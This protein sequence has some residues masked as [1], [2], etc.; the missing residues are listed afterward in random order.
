MSKWK[1][2]IRNKI[3]DSKVEE[4]V[5]A[6]ADGEDETISQV[7]KQLLE[8][9]STLE[10]SY[11]IP[12][13]SRIESVSTLVFI[14]ADIQ[15]D[16]EDEA[17]TTT[18]AEANSYTPI[19]EHRR[20]EA[21]EN[22]PSIQ[23]E[24]APVRPRPPPIFARPRPAPPPPPPAKPTPTHSNDRLKLDAIIAL[25]QQTVAAANNAPAG[26]PAASAA[27]ESSRSGSRPVDEF[28]A[29]NDERRKRVKRGHTE[30]EERKEKRLT[31]LVGEVVVRSMSKY[32]EQ[33]EHDTFKRYAKEVSKTKKVVC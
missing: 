29:G 17:G 28:N 14:S 33:M 13:V 21:W 1:L 20:P 19:R 12:R 11:R 15:L 25:A 22:T 30:D 3:E 16:A 10:L 2:Q 32:K 8:Y 24:I 4:P 9:W 31:K 5:R 23:L 7:A 18:I 6:L 27:A 26:S